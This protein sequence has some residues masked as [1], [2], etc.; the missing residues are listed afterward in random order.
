MTRRERFEAVMK[1]Q[2]VD[3]VI[4]DFAG[5]PQTGVEAGCTEKLKKLLGIEGEYTG[6]YP[7][8]DERILEALDIDT[9]RVG[10]LFEPS[11]PLIRIE[12]KRAYDCWG[13]G[14][15]FTGLYWDIVE[16]P[17]RG[18]DEKMIEDYP[19][20]DAANI[21]RKMIH[22]IAEQAKRLYYDTEYVVCAEHPTYGVM[23][24]GCW[25]MGFDEYLYKLAIEPEVIEKFSNRVLQ[26]QKDVFELY[27]GAIGDYIH[28][29]TCGDD[30]GMQSGSFM[31]KDMFDE[32]ILP[33]IKERVKTIKS[34]TKGYFW[35]HTCGSV[36]NL[37][38]SL[39]EAGVDILNPIQ[40]GA[41][42]MEPDKLKKAYGDKIVF[43]G[44]V[45][46]QHLLVEGTVDDVK[47]SV[48]QILADMQGTGYVLAAAH[49]IQCDVPAE[50][51]LAIFQ[52]ANEY[53]GISH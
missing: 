29:T 52:G 19:F 49:N 25:M 2:P 17:L 44:G 39:I 42:D 14:R 21:D 53:F 16:N 15:E 40:P 5:T 38:P 26:Y 6:S 3:R 22:A 31:S 24:I 37:I 47:A 34:M 43:W 45:D 18:C 48:K 35:Q 33:Y 13:V 27:Y 7:M 11:S 30:Y 46:T 23:E 20:P 12:G 36:F 51:V 50:N 4:Y 8:Y 28:L 1:K 10:A 32:M 9:R 41:K